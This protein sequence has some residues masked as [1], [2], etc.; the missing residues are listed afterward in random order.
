M[1]IFNSLFGGKNKSSSNLPPEVTQILELFFSMYH[2]RKSRKAPIGYTITK[3][4]N[5]PFLYGTN[6]RVERFPYG[7][8]KAIR[9]TTKKM[10]GLPL[11]PPQV[12]Q[13]E[14]RIQFQRPREHEERIKIAT[15]SVQTV[16]Y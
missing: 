5:Q 8:Q 4:Q 9:T 14:E 2:P 12:R 16:T 10:I 7:L 11:P 6:R 1:G 15:A 13:A 3:L